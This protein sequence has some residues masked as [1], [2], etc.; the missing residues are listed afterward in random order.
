M[1]WLTY[2]AWSVIIVLIVLVLIRDERATT[3]ELLQSEAMAFFNKDVSIRQWGAMHGGV[4]VPPSAKTPPNPYLSH[5]L[6]RDIVSSDGKKLTLVNPAY[7]FRQLSELFSAKFGIIGHITSRKLLRPENKPDEWEERALEQFEDGV[8]QA[9]TL[10]TIDGAQ[11]YRFM[12]PLT[13][14]K[15]CL[16]CHGHQGYE[17]GDIRGGVSLTLPIEKYRIIE[18]RKIQLI[19]EAAALLWFLGIIGAFFAFRQINIGL[20]AH[21]DLETELVLK[22]KRNREILDTVQFGIFI[23][24]YQTQTIDYTN[25]ALLALSGYSYDDLI[26]KS[27]HQLICQ[28]KDKQCPIIDLQ[29]KME[30]L[31]TEL[32]CAD[33]S[34][35]EVVKTAKLIETTAGPKVI[36]SFADISALKKNQ[37]L[38]AAHSARTSEINDLQMRLFAPGKL[39]DKLSMVCENL[40]TCF[41][42]YLCRIWILGPQDRCRKDCF[43]ANSSNEERYCQSSASCLHLQASGGHAP[44]L[45]GEHARIPAGATLIGQLVTE[46]YPSFLSNQ[47]A[48]DPLTPDH[49]WAR[50]HDLVS[51]AGYSLLDQEYNAVGVLAMFAKHQLDDDDDIHLNRMAEVVSQVIVTEKATNELAQA[52]SNAERLNRLSMGR[53]KK[54]IAMKQE[55]NELLSGA[56]K[57]LKY[58]SGAA[59]HG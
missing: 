13:I 52:L 36:E 37:A 4:Y 48:T 29:Q 12:R 44:P 59:E 24:D 35:L 1:K 15:G 56:G 39:A 43:H 31:E 32:C 54:I 40:V 53:E 45:N 11:V 17:I 30:N 47:V 57:P 8:E 16:K 28:K 20:R 42:L 22:E 14:K 34:T 18:R 27:C 21:E 46:K 9:S 10:S 50:E 25:P 55:V 58:K 7:M 6:D 49:Q 26:G 33:G 19:V 38:L 2:G 51:F 5:L 23:I 41:D 3:L